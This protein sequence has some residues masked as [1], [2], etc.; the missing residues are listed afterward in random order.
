MAKLTRG[1]R[2]VGVTAAITCLI[3]LGFALRPNLLLAEEEDNAKCFPPCRNGYQCY[4][5]ECKSPCNPVCRTGYT[6][7]QKGRCIAANPPVNEGPTVST[8]N[9]TSVAQLSTDELLR[10]KQNE[11]YNELNPK[12]EAASRPSSV[13]KNASS[14]VPNCL[15]ANDRPGPSPEFLT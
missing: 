4:A 3:I 13:W 11:E 14:S 1:D 7:T 12:T 6:C 15:P 8:R 10:K 9:G 5:G 2:R